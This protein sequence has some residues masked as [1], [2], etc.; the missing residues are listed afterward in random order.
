VYHVLLLL[1]LAAGVVSELIAITVPDRVLQIEEA[2]PQQM[3][4]SRFY[5][6]IFGLSGFYLT[7]II[8]MFFTAEHFFRLYATI[9]LLNSLVIWIVRRWLMRFRLVFVLE[10]TLCLILLLDSC[11]VLIKDLI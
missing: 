3:L 8:L 11:R 1:C 2:E 7:G 10:A 4:Q 6:V 5:K 9:L